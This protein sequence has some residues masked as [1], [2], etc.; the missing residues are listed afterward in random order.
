MQP[1]HIIVLNGTS[2]SG[3][4][5]LAK[6]LQD[7]MPVPYLHT[8]ID[9]F[10]ERYP[11]RMIVR[12]DGVNPASAEGWLATFHDN[13]LVKVQI[14]PL[15]YKLIAG[16]YQAIATLA[17]AG[18]NVI[19]DDVIYDQR[20]LRSAVA[21]LHSCNVLFVGIRCPL[22]VAERRER[23]RGNR[24][25]GGAKTFYDLVHVPRIYDLEVDTAAAS[26]L[27]CALAIKHSLPTQPLPHAF[28]R[29][30]SRLMNEPD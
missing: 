8:G 4:T 14:G 30:K 2:S 16:M 15:G 12:S 23:E 9:H 19:V 21:A 28:T 27:D 7:V 3:K 24:A 10:L 20:V 6:A 26:P 22:D 13:V 1:G 17:D 11:S 18:I 29:L 25:V 5:T